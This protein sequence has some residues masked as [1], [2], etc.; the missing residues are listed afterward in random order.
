[1]MQISDP[2]NIVSE[3]E[4]HVYSITSFPDTGTEGQEGFLDLRASLNQDPLLNPLFSRHRKAYETAI[5]EK[6][7]LKLRPVR[8]NYIGLPRSGK[9]SLLH[10]LMGKI[11]NILAAMARGEFEQPSTGLAENGGL[12]VIIRCMSLTFGVLQ[13]GV[14][15]SLKHL[16]EEAS[17][18]NQLIYEAVSKKPIASK[19]HMASQVPPVEKLEAAVLSSMSGES[20]SASSKCSS[21]IIYR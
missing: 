13:S 8:V 4:I 3:T 14:W 21:R 16:G 11:E 20:S 9:T 6:V 1:M 7:T 2:V 18:L 5:K 17:M 19:M 10:R 15:Y 12:Q